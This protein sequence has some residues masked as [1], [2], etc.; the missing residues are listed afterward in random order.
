MET[1]LDYSDFRNANKSDNLLLYSVI[2]N[3]SYTLL[4]LK[5]MY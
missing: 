3:I 4:L 5:Y 2:L 1:I